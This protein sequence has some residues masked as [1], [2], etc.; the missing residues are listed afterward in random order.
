MLAIGI[1]EVAYEECWKFKA[2]SSVFFCEF[3]AGLYY[4]SVAA[5]RNPRPISMLPAS[6]CRNRE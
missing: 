2:A 1:V 3:P 5:S 4:R 6:L